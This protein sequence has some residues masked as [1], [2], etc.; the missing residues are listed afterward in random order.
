[1]LEKNSSEIEKKIAQS[2]EKTKRKRSD[3][4]VVA[5][6]KSVSADQT[7]ALYEKGIRDLAENR[8]EGLLLKQESL[9]DPEINWHYIGKL[10]TRKVKK[11]IN[12][13]DYLHSLDRMALVEEIEKRAGKKISCFVQVNVT[14]EQSKSGIAPI[15]L[16]HFIREIAP[17][18]KIE[19]IGLMTMAPLHAEEAVIRETFKEL[20]E[21]QKKIERKGFAH[22]PCTELSMGMSEDYPIAIEEGSTFVRIGRAFFK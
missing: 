12:Q 4:R 9:S 17:F 2:L 21:L 3:I 8:P 18:K 11:V 10:Q 20:K 14:G 15:E 7:I 6:T 16:E 1:M 5:V 13:I 22:A 19:V